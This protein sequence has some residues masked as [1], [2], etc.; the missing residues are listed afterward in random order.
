MLV[1][2]VKTKKRGHRN[3]RSRKGLSDDEAEHHVRSVNMP[4]YDYI[5]PTS[6]H[7]DFVFQMQCY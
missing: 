2:R 1:T 6:Q 7:A 4:N 3:I 5:D